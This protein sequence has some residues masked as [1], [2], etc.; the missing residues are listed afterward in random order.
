MDRLQKAIQK[1]REERQSRESPAPVMEQPP[2]HAPSEDA[3]DARWQSVPEIQIDPKLAVRNR[4]ASL[5]GGGDATPYDMLRTKML[6]QILSNKWRRVALTSPYSGCG[7]STTTANLAFSLGRQ[8][9]L[10]TIVID[11]DMRRRGLAEIL[12][13]TGNHSMADVIQGSV[14]FHEHALRYGK[15]V[16][17]GLNY[18]PTRNPAEILQS[19]RAIEFLE[20][21]EADYKPDVI[22]FD[23][24]PLMMSDDSHGF[25]R[26]VDC[27][28]LLA[29]A[30]ETSI[31]HIDVSEQ[32][33]AELTSVMGIVLNKCRY[34]SGTF[35]NEYGSY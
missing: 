27:A 23:T 26:N 17:F 29:A 18:T 31:D 19:R 9:D 2:R 4:L 30:E 8:E 10:R 6:Q 21:L 35:G 22:L 14:P 16:I 20:Q 3:C 24:P 13:Q 11:F 25:L 34:I 33:L 5:A 1:A 28:L 7:K 15:N 32:Q 12:K